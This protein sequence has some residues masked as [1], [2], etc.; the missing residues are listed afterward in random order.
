MNF[1]PTWL[2][3]FNFHTDPYS[4]PQAENLPEEIIKSLFVFRVF[5]PRFLDPELNILNYPASTV[6]HGWGKTM[7]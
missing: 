2:R 5:E 1:I 4:C 3:P 7:G 6:I